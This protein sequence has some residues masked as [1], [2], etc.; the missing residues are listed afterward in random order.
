MSEKKRHNHKDEEIN[1]LK[2]E[3]IKAI[4][5]EETEASEKIE[6][7][8]IEIEPGEIESLKQK[9]A[10]AEDKSAVNLDGWQR[11]VAEFQNYKKRMERDREAEKAYMMSDLIKKVLPVL[12]DLERALLNRPE[13]DAWASGIELIT[14]KLQFI[15]EAEGLE[16]IEAAGAAFDPNFHEAISYEAV[17]GVESGHIIAIVQNGYMLGDRVVRPALVRV[18]K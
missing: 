6:T 4:Q 13:Q 11:S 17:E 16:R 1:T 8:N 10:E 14:R 5:D 9:V 7:V 2:D 12:D 18:A 3:E 15:L